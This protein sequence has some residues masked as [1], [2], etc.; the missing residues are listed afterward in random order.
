MIGFRPSLVLVAVVAAMLAAGCEIR[1]EDYGADGS[2]DRT[3]HVA[4]PA[5]V[6]VIRR[7]GTIRIVDGAADQVRIAGRIRAYGSFPGR[8]CIWLSC[9]R[10]S[11]RT[12]M[13]RH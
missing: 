10:G 6:S 4:G 3:L 12:R 9:A 7:S 2:F 5:E 11:S 8:F 1:A 13:A